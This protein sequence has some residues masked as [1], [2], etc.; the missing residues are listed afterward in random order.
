MKASKLLQAFA[1]TYI[2]QNQT[3]YYHAQL[4]T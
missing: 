4:A 2:L 3:E 1:G